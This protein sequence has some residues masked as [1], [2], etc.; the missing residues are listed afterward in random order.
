MGIR[1]GVDTGG[2]FTDLVAID[3]EKHTLYT[4]KEPSTPSRPVAAL[5]AVLEN[6]QVDLQRGTRTVLGTTVATNAILERNGAQVLFL[7]TQGIEDVLFIQRINRP[8]NY[9]L[10]WQKPAPLVKRRHCLGVN[11]RI[12]YKG[13]VV[14][15]LTDEELRRVGDQVEAITIQ[16]E[17]EALA[18]CLLFAYVNP[19][20]EAKL[21]AY[22]R[23]RFP[24]LPQS[25]SHQLVPIW[26][27]YE[28]SSTTVADAF[29]KPLIMRYVTDAR[30]AYQNLAVSGVQCLMKSNGGM[31][32]L[33]IV[34][35]R[36]S[37]T[38]L[39]GLVAGVI[40][41]NFFGQLTGYENLITLD[42]GG[43]S[44]DVG[45]IVDPC[46][47]CDDDRCRWWIHR[48][49]GSGWLSSRWTAECWCGSWS[50]GLRCRRRATDGNGC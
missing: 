27:E 7:T 17:I 28:R 14:Q 49:G 36:P 9:D 35:D 37:D 39:S 8:H 10:R 13:V 1:M 43:T 18:I 47:R 11:E 50:S 30:C 31:T 16:D 33:D 5:Q 23:K 6:S 42:L 38:L 45:L 32:L 29:V 3:E 4:R 15:P 22:L 20:H 19:E 2:T 12:N 25:V 46:C 40:A 48:L 24:D 21:D 44:C 26:R 34:V 41:G